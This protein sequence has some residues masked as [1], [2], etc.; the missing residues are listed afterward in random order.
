MQKLALS[1]ISIVTINWKIKTFKDENDIHL[2]VSVAQT[3]KL[4]RLENGLNILDYGRLRK[5]GKISDDFLS[6]NV[7]I[8]WF[9]F[10]L[11]DETSFLLFGLE[12]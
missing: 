8:I 9:V 1:K 7:F 11:I 12:V 6:C 4:M 3:I 10:L 2:I 5:A